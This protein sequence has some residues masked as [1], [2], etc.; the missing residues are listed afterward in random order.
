MGV[1]RRYTIEDG[2]RLV[3]A[4]REAIELKLLSPRFRPQMVERNLEGFNDEHG[5]FVAIAHYPTNELR[6]IVGFTSPEA[7]LG[8]SLVEAAVKAAEDP[9]FVPLSHMEFDHVVV[10]VSTLSKPELLRNDDYEAIKSEIELGR[11]GMAIASG[12]HTGVML[13]FMAMK[14]NW[15]T[16]EFLAHLCIEAGLQAHSWKNPKVI[17]SKFRTQTFRET[18]PRGRVDEE[19]ILS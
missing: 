5:V 4:A 9:R 19:I 15:S 3:K 10:R 12:Y 8:R 14:N 7:P 16:D 13:P 6:G 17:L 1:D 2:A 18:V 11:D